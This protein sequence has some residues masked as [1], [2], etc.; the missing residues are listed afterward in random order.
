MGKAR[1]Q[2]MGEAHLELLAR[3]LV[4]PV[5]LL[6]LEGADASVV[7]GYDTLQVRYKT[8]Q[9]RM[10]LVRALHSKKYTHAPP[11]RRLTISK[12]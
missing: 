5:V 8:K 12:F 3:H 10:L 4:L 1:S 2:G 9:S 7:R 6:L 11:I